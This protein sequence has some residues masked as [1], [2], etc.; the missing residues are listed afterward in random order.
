[1]DLCGGAEDSE[2][3][4]S[5]IDSSGFYVKSDSV[6]HPYKFPKVRKCWYDYYVTN[7]SLYNAPWRKS[8]GDTYCDDTQTCTVSMLTGTEVCQSRTDGVDVN[9]GLEFIKIVAAIF[10]IEYHVSLSKTACYTAS[11]TTA[12]AWDDGGC[13]TVF[14]SQQLLKQTGYRRKRCNWGDG[15]ETECMADIEINTPTDLTTYQ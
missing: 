15:D 9:V 4:G 8:S 13:H 2:Y 11:N 10:G 1:M 6:S 3:T 12:C 7:A 5:H 14:T